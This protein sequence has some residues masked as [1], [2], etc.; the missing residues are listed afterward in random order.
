MRYFLG[1]GERTIMETLIERAIRLGMNIIKKK[2]RCRLKAAQFLLGGHKEYEHRI[3][4][5]L[6]AKSAVVGECLEWTARCNAGGYGAFSIFTRPTGAHKAAYRLFNGPIPAGM[7][8]LHKCDNRKCILPDHL[9]LGTIS[10]NMR[11]KFL[12]GRCACGDKN[13]TRTHPERLLRGEDR[14]N[15]KLTEHDVRKIRTSLTGGVSQRLLAR[16]FNVDRGS[17]AAIKQGTGWRHVI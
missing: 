16:Q 14:W 12:K 9:F 4:S 7:Q 11:D 1:S 5:R 8:V 13:G 17:I 6:L 15:A 10:D 3:K 2:E